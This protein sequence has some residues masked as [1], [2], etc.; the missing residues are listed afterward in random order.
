MFK[1]DAL[2]VNL[3]DDDNQ[4]SGDLAPIEATLSPMTSWERSLTELVA[5][6][7]V[8]EEGEG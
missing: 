2:P 7:N 6:Q 3:V 8:P 5:F 4:D 1:I